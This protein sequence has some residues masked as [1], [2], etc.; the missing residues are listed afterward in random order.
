MP[1]ALK[2]P[3]PRPDQPTSK[4]IEKCL[5]RCAFEEYLPEAVCFRQKEQFS[6]G[7]S[8]SWIDSL[9]KHADSTVSDERFAKRAEIYPFQTPDSKEALLYRDI[10]EQIFAESPVK[11]GGVSQAAVFTQASAACSTA[12]ALRWL[13]SGDAVDPSGRSIG[14][15]H[16]Q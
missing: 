2:L 4:P 10:F 11:T 15:V 8:Y 14:R 13:S 1:A 12:S 9:K 16:G 6:D 7:V 3:L 5:L